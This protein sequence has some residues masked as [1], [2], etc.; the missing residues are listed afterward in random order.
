[1]EHAGIELQRIDK[2]GGG[3]GRGIRGAKTAGHA[4]GV[5]RLREAVLPGLRERLRVYGDQSSSAHVS[6]TSES[7]LWAIVGRPAVPGS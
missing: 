2:H 5:S 1:M 7:L 4:I 3:L 6:L